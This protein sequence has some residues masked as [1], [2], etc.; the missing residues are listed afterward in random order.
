MPDT[1]IDI[2]PLTPERRADFLDFFEHRA[3]TDNPKWLSCY[4]HYP[5]ADHA[6]IV[7]KERSAEQNRAA[8]CERI[9]QR[10]M[11]G[12]L[13]Y[14]GHDADALVVAWCNAGPRRFIDGLFDAPEPLAEQIG[15]VACFV[16][17]PAWR[18]RGVARSL[19]DAACEGFRASGLIWA[20]GYPQCEANGAAENHLG[21]L[22]MYTAAGFEVVKVEGEGNMV[23]RKRLG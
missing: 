14:A 18:G 10:T 6:G 8:T 22:S 23:V 15:A 5:H 3:F 13:A 21:P 19:L 2:R 7:W 9:D 16:V 12:W 11:T 20:E 4:C 17:A 1:A